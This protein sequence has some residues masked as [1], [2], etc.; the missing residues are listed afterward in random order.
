MTL[1]HGWEFYMHHTKGADRIFT[2]GETEWN[3]YQTAVKKVLPSEDVVAP[4]KDL[5]QDLGI[6]SDYGAGGN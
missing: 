3:H 2:P 1:K 5:A 6:N 4:L